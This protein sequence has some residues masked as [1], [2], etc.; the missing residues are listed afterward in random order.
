[1]GKAQGDGFRTEFESYDECK[2]YLSEYL[3][4]EYDIDGIMMET[5]EWD[6][7]SIREID[8]RRRPTI[9]HIVWD[10]WSVAERYA[11]AVNKSNFF[12]ATEANF[13]QCAKPKR[14]PDYVSDS[15]SAYWYL[16]EGVVRQ[17]DH[18]GY[19][20]ASCTWLLDGAEYG[21]R[22]NG[23]RLCGFCEWQRFTKKN[24]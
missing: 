18:W 12:I 11:K 3:G 22:C 20:I 21:M 5:A 10:I 15:G 17:A 6:I 4:T 2:R 19:R 9:Y 23:D 7:E 16:A 14:E 8:G 1:M 13:E 24:A